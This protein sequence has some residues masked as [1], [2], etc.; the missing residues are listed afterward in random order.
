MSTEEIPLPPSL[1]VVPNIPWHEQTINQLQ[2]EWNYWDEQ[3]RGA[4]EWGVSFAFAMK[5]RAAC[6]RWLEKRLREFDAAA[7]ERR[8]MELTEA[9]PS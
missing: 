6:E 9:W 1:A 7:A 4:P 8:A 2:A 5:E 3:V